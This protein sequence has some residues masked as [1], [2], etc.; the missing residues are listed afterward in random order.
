MID[1][2]GFD[3]RI[4]AELQRDARQSHVALAERVPLSASQIQRRLKRLEG[5]GLVRGYAALLD[6]EAVGLGVLAFT[7]VSLERHGDRPAA[8][9]EEAVRAIPEVLDC[10]AVSG[11]D[12]YL[13][14]IVAADLK[15]FSDL[16]MHR[17][18]P[19]PGV[20][21]VRSNIVLGRVKDSVALPL[22]HL[23]GAAGR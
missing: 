21:S 8:A 5:A 16:L 9:F 18:L 23:P 11:E 13:L 17:L 4:L 14:R 2:D 22:G 6:A 10:Y 1:L 12:D 15:A 3:I 19:A 20:R 7:S